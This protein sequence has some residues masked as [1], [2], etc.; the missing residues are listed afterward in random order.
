[1]AP[2]L[3]GVAAAARG[4]VPPET[5][6]QLQEALAAMGATEDWAAL[7]GALKEVLAGK[8]DFDALARG[9]DEVDRQALA[10]VRAAVSSDEGFA[11]LQGLA[12]MA[13]VAQMSPEER[14][15]LTEGLSSVFAEQVVQAA[16]EALAKGQAGALAAQ[17]EGL[18]GQL[19]E[20]EPEGSP[21][22]QLARF[23]RAVAA[24]LRGQEPEAVPE[25]FAPYV[26]A[27]TR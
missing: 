22:R 18:A 7:A 27:L 16:K 11:L 21:A 10:L 1:M 15:A 5:V 4:L 23:L 9:L 6:G 19:P 2:L 25:Q 17:L 3:L 24:I 20:G 26:E 14:Q 12:A 13:A 8:R